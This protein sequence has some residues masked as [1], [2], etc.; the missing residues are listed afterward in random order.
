MQ[1]LEN[2]GVLWPKFNFCFSEPGK[3]SPII[4][5]SIISLTNIT[6]V[7]TYHII[8][9][10]AEC[11][12]WENNPKVYNQAH[13]IPPATVISPATQQTS[14]I[15]TKVETYH[16]DIELPRASKIETNCFIGLVKQKFPLSAIIIHPVFTE[17]DKRI[18]NSTHQHANDYKQPN[19]RKRIQLTCCALTTQH[20]N[21]KCYDTGINWETIQV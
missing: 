11:D 9:L 3:Y 8:Q 16:V 21:Y 13:G 18:I 19:S 12:N 7:D 4:A 2:A 5:S 20:M 14:K 17:Q 1:L 10:C 15:A 6:T